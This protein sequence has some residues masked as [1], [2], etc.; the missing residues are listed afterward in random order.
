[1]TFQDL[2]LSLVDLSPNLEEAIQTFQRTSLERLY[3]EQDGV[4]EADIRP[5]EVLQPRRLS[6]MVRAWL[7]R[8]GSS[9]LT[10]LGD[11]GSGKP[12]SANG[13]PGTSRL[14]PKSR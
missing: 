6:E 14:A 7:D 1:M 3:V 13:C 10:L 8:P 2:V 11:F 12:A 4:F 5:D 9:F